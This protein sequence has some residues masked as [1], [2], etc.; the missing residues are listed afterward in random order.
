MDLPDR[1]VYLLVASM[2]LQRSYAVKTR[3]SIE[4]NY[5]NDQPLAKMSLS[6]V[7]KTILT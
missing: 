6:I 5:S 1:L 2:D 3:S 4:D 7:R